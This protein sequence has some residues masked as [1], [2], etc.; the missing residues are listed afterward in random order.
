MHFLYKTRGLL[1]KR[2][3]VG[4]NIIYTPRISLRCCGGIRVLGTRGLS[5][6]LSRLTIINNKIGQEA[7]LKGDSRN[8]KHVLFKLW[9]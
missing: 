1:S 2:S 5:P 4:N 9:V 8:C 3:F 7:S 6:I